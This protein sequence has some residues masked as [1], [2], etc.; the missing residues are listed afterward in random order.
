VHRKNNR[1]VGFD[2]TPYDPRY[3]RQFLHAD[4]VILFS[5][6]RFYLYIHKTAK[7]FAV[8]ISLHARSWASKCRAYVA[9][10][11]CECC[12]WNRSRKQRPTYT[13]FI[14]VNGYMIWLGEEKYRNK[15]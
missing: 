1:Y 6:L 7:G 11:Q 2:A 15:Y 8:D 13:F 14:A 10:T 4:Q 5:P 3:W 12:Y 9:N